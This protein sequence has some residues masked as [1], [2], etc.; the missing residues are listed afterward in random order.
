MFRFAPNIGPMPT[1]AGDSHADRVRAAASASL[2][3]VEVACIR[4]LVS[5]YAR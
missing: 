3:A 5:D 2:Y 1:E 4:E